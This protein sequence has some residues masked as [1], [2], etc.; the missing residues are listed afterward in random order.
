MLQVTQISRQ[1]QNMNVAD[2]F[3]QLAPAK[4]K[5]VVCFCMDHGMIILYKL[6][7]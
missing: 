2:T 6:F 4:K 1:D 3:E 7:E 5:T